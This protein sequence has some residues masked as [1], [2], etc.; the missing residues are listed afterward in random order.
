[1]R[2]VCAGALLQQGGGGVERLAVIGAVWDEELP[3]AHDI[4]GEARIR[5]RYQADKAK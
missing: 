5:F 2:R 3:R 1:M 4:I